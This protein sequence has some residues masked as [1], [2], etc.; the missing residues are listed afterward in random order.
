MGRAGLRLLFMLFVLFPFSAFAGVTDIGSSHDAQVVE[1]YP[2]N[3]YG[4]QTNMYVAS[5]TGSYENER[6]WLMFDL[7][8]HLP[9]GAIITSA[10]LRLYCYASDSSDNMP[11]AVHGSEND[12]WS[13]SAISWNTQPAYGSELSRVTMTAGDEDHW[14]EWDVTAFVQAQWA[15]DSAKKASFVVKAVTEGQDPWRTYQFDA[16]EFSTSLA[17]RL[18]ITYSGEW[19]A[20]NGFTIFHT[21]DAHSRL[22]PHEFDI[23]GTDDFAVFEKTGGAAYLTTR[24]LAL[25][26]AEPDS[27]IL[28][29]GDI[30]EGSPLG[31][32]RGNGG[33]V[34]FYNLLDS[35]LRALGGRGI[36]AV[37][38][39]N[40]DVRSLEMIRNMK[41]NATFPVISMNICHDGTQ[42]PYFAPYAIVTVNGTKV[43]IL[44]FTNDESSY[45]GDD[46][47]PLIDIVKCAWSDNNSATIDIKDYVRD[48]RETENC[49]VVVLLVHIGHRRLVTSDT[50]GS[51][52][53]LI[54]DTDGVLPPEVV[55]SGHWHTWTET[56]WQPPHLDGK[57]LIA[58]AASYMQYI[59]EL[60][61]TGYGKYVQAAKHPVRNADITPDPDV[62]ALL[63][64]LNAE[65]AAAGGQ[66]LEAVIGYSAMDLTLDKD[67][68]WTV[69][70]YPWSAT[71]A[72]GAWICDA[73][74][75]KA[76]ALGYPADLAI[77]SGGG[78]RRDVPAGPITYRQIYETYPWVDDNMVRVQ[79]TGQQI[80]RFLED[81][82]CGASISKDWVVT[83]D[84]GEITAVT[85]Q[86]SPVND[87][88]S[89][90]VLISE[91]MQAHEMADYC[92]DTT[93]EDLNYS[94]RSSVVDFTGQYTQA[95]PMTIPG[96][97]YVLNTEF[98]GGFKAVVTMTADM[99]REPYFE[100]VFI[101][102]LEADTGTLLRRN[103]YGL[104]SLVQ[105]DG[106]INKAAQFSETMLYRSHLGFKDG[107][108][109]PG[110]I[111]EIQGEGGFYA[112]NPQFVDQ[113]GI[114]DADTEMRITGH[115][116]TAAQPAYYPTIN[117][118]MD[119]WHENHYV[120]FYAEKTGDTT[121][122][123]AEG[124]QI[125]LFQ[126]GGYSEKTVPGA[127]GGLLEI[128]GV[129]TQ[130]FE[131]R[132]FRCHT[133]IPVTETDVVGYPPYSSVDPVE[134]A[135]TTT[136]PLTLTVTA[137]DA[138]T[139]G[140]ADQIEP[141][142]AADARVEAAAP[143]TNYGNDNLLTVQSAD[144]QDKR[145]WLRFDLS[146]LL[147]EN[148]TVTD[149][150]LMLRPVQLNGGDFEVAV[151]GASDDSW[152]E[153]SIT[154]NTQ[155]ATG[156]VLDTRTLTSGMLYAYQTWDVTNFVQAQVGAAD[157]VITLAARAAVE[158]AAAARSVL[159]TS[160]DY[161]TDY[162]PKLSVTYTVGSGTAAVTGVTVEYRYSTDRLNWGDWD[163]VAHMTAA[164]WSTAF[165]Y[166]DGFG[167]YEFRSMATDADGNSEAQPLT[168]DATVRYRDGENDP[169]DPAADPGIPDGESNVDRN[170]ILSATISDAD[171]DFSDVFFYGGANGS[172][173]LLGSALGVPS[174]QT[175]TLFWTG[176]VLDST[177]AWYVVTDDGEQSS[178]SP[179]WIFATGEPVSPVAVPGAG[180]LAL[181][182]GLV[183]L[184]GFGLM[185]IRRTR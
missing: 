46:T 177:Y 39:G 180:F 176:L 52:P 27:L 127:V 71:N 80:R 161:N 130:R 23:P 122:R 4:S 73:M 43:G 37:V 78:I 42:N 138:E 25:K 120:Q 56:V 166:P 51:A 16:K 173:E 134:P 35:K 31:D 164:P 114:A 98:A 169:P 40:H 185:R 128:T 157:T 68:W 94:I 142:V 183:L 91:Y 8:R 61:V 119:E 165:S 48:L 6:A 20:G 121:V 104:D 47:D 163:T 123:D 105:Y 38:V 64:T 172:F 14:F 158:G 7:N 32:L 82:Y 87:S 62:L 45:L 67:K 69:S 93:P 17:P 149:A 10:A 109:Q 175:A 53:A 29:A 143:D 102:L 74:Q 179:T 174:G 144:S 33:M 126:P 153:N 75:W 66:P 3:N 41:N 106:S 96:P 19:P 13:E 155:A 139:P 54:A 151:H 22:L 146:A 152:T 129:N 44:G 15:G 147:P 132:R 89:Y 137:G 178:Q 49:D 76:E 184:S 133:A 162:A 115:D 170:T 88:G 59:G 77:Q 118:F 135:V 99:E 86:G 107:Q 117:A 136:R 95:A 159:F 28:D 65:Y 90:N 36:D 92:T 113:E 111:I 72:A 124:T 110:D 150:R 58:E 60:E 81:K 97:R 125:T 79:M 112:G 141:V 101:R 103:Q 11:T 21:N 50:G 148:V 26:A 24:M 168:A 5:S 131:D 85:Y 30:S 70:E 108:L 34:D 12:T 154:W 140:N 83:A 55:I 18:R 9:P 63:D 156:A 1:G 84:D 57:T 2:S 100:A 145:V 167:Y 181:V 160:R 171:H 182:S 116:E